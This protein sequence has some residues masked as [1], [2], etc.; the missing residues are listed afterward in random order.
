M[1]SWSGEKPQLW[2]GAHTRSEFQLL[3]S[4]WGSWGKAFV[5][6]DRLA[7]M[8]CWAKWQSPC[9]AVENANEPG[10]C[11]LAVFPGSTKASGAL[12]YLTLI[13][14]AWLLPEKW[15]S[16]E[17]G[18]S[19]GLFFKSENTQKGHVSGAVNICLHHLCACVQLI[20]SQLCFLVYAEA[21]L[22][23]WIPAEVFMTAA[24]ASSAW[25]DRSGQHH[26]ARSKWRLERGK[27]WISF[28]L[29]TKLCAETG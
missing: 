24:T 19:A 9:G 11:S 18:G 2:G 13:W 22:K 21:V 16:A 20:Q 17:K 3:N 10:C 4:V 26:Q 23:T 29:H 27:P 7:V 1:D 8:W 6:T 28:S 12:M 5:W 14:P 25:S 15:R